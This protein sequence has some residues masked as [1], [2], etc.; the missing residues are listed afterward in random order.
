MHTSQYL[1][2]GLLKVGFSLFD[3]YLRSAVLLL[4]Q[5]TGYT[6]RGGADAIGRYAIYVKTVLLIYVEDFTGMLSSFLFP[7]PTVSPIKFENICTY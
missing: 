1:T 6:P 7:Q 5:S 2:G 3:V 4:S